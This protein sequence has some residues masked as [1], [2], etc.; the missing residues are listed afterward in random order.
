MKANTRP[1]AG[2]FELDHF[3]RTT[4]SGFLNLISQLL[5][6][7]AREFTALAQ[8]G[9]LLAIGAHFRAD[10]TAVFRDVEYFRTGGLA[11]I[12][13]NA[14][15]FDPNALDSHSDAPVAAVCG[16]LRAAKPSN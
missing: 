12:A 10:M 3:N 13:N 6:Q 11:G 5:A 15:F 4:F 1:I 8:V 16:L 2:L 7:N 14:A 9:G